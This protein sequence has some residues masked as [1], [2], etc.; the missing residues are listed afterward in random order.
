LI[1]D[2]H[3]HFYDPTRPSGVPWPNPD[4]KFLYRPIMPDNFKKES[5]SEGVT[6][7]IVVEASKWIQDN[8]WILD[9]A[10]NDPFLLG[11]VGHLEPTD[12]KF[13]LELEKFAEHDL[14]YGIR[15]GKFSTEAPT[16]LQAL[17]QLVAKDLSLDLLIGMDCLQNVASY[18]TKFPD[19][20]IIINHLGH[21]PITGGEPN[22]EW[23]TSIKLVAKHPN[24]FCKISGMVELSEVH[25]PPDDPNFYK[26]VLDVLWET[27]GEERLLYASNWPVSWRFAS[28]KEV[29]SLA[30]ACFRSKG[31]KA[32]EKIMWGNSREAY[33]WIARV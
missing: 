32:V 3:T 23:I 7:T 30:L 18:A 14:F 29:Q 9:L 12:P 17:E 6:G 15:L 1:I 2:T 4:D 21:V 28:Y 33:K 13:E 8:Q 20:R 26:P 16:Y 10:E 24:V 19:L 5:L 25:P 27:F 22:E 11:L 31:S